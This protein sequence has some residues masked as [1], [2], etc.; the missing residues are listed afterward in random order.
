MDWAG[1][2]GDLILCELPSVLRHGRRVPHLKLAK[3]EVHYLVACD[4]C[5]RTLA[6]APRAVCSYHRR[7]ARCRENS[8]RDAP[9][10]HK[11]AHQFASLEL[12]KGDPSRL[13]IKAYQSISSWP[14][15]GSLEALFS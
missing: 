12:A 7:A 1:R 8:H 14:Q 4:H 2:C 13:S 5:R 9:V 6:C 11:P 10:G 3:L 15:A